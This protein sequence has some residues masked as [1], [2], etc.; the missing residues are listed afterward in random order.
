MK[1]SF[2]EKVENKEK[3]SEDKITPEEFFDEHEKAIEDYAGDTGIIFR[4]GNRWAINMEEGEATY[5]PKFFNEKGYSD[6]EA[7]WATC[8]EVEHFRNWLM[9]PEAY[10]KLFSKIKFRRRLRVLYNCLDDIMVGR[11][12]DKRFPAHK[13]TKKFL[14]KEKLFPKEGFSAKE[15]DN[16]SRSALPLHLQFAYTM[17]REKMVPEEVLEIDPK[18]RKEIEKLKN[19]DGEGTDLI[20]LVSDPQADPEDRYEIIRDFIEPIYEKFFQEDVEKKK[21]GGDKG[22]DQ[23]EGRSKKKEDYFED[24]YDDFDDK[25]PEPIPLDDIKEEL[26]KKIKEIKEKQKSSEEKAKDQFEKEYGVSAEEIENYRSNYKKI[27]RY[28]EPL[29][30]IFERIIS[31]RK[32]IKR[33][34]KER[35]DQGVIIDPSMIT[36]AYIDAKSGVLDSRTQLKIRK[37]EHDENKP[38]DFEFSLI[39][40]LS[41]SMKENYPGGKSYEQKMCAILIMEALAEFEEKLKEEREEKNLNLHVLT[42][43]RGFGSEDEELKEMSDTIDYKTRVK[44]GK[45]LASCDAGSTCDYLSLA[46]IDKNI[47]EEVR[48]KIENNDLKKIVLLITDGGSDDIRQAKKEKKA[49]VE[50]GVIT[51]AIQIGKAGKGDKERFKEVWQRPKKDGYSCKSV[52]SLVPT[53]EKLLEDFLVDL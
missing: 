36:Q 48:R 18:V 1:E 14:Y 20:S 49:L 53:V 5:D 30:E 35:T 38:S 52:S 12:V 44:I 39:C 8:H 6:A 42:E 31:T 26:D 45:R 51:K 22:E 21:K 10:S 34:L 29:R 15:S 25:M 9:N 2:L 24:E 11:E 16:K 19:I 27:E 37:E 13:E 46:K 23:E 17:L 7:M 41:G 50:A 43:V 40:D 4:K 28:I 47:D 3:S 33:K 32:E